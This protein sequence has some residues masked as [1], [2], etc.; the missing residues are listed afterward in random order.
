MALIGTASLGLTA[1][2]DRFSYGEFGT[3]LMTIDLICV[4]N[5]VSEYFLKFPIYTNTKTINGFGIPEFFEDLYGIGALVNFDSFRNCVRW[6]RFADR[7]SH[8]AA[9]I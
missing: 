9:G 8:R 4:G 7:N 3:T 6:K 5:K 2:L 1:F